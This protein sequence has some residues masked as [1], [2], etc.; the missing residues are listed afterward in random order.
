MKTLTTGALSRWISVGALVVV[1]AVVGVQLQNPNSY[2]SEAVS[3]VGEF[4]SGPQ[5]GLTDLTS[6][7][8][9]ETRFN[10]DSGHPRLILL[11]SPT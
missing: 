6:V 3:R 7:D 2:V 8:Q 11:F 1:L 4:G 9:L 10:R 5:A